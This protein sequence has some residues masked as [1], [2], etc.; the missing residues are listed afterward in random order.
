MRRHWKLLLGIV[1][2]LVLALGAAGYV[3]A[4]DLPDPMPET[5]A[6]LV[7]DDVVAVETEPWLAFIPAEPAE[8]GFIFYPGGRVPAQAY[9]PPAR[10]IAQAGYLTVVPS[11]PFGLAVLAPDTADGIIEAYPEV[12]RWVIG[13]HS[14]G[15]A[16]AA[17]YAASHDTIEGLALWAAYPAGGTDLS[18]AP[19]AATSIYAS[20]DGLA[21]IEEI[22]GS[23]VQLPPDT[24]FVEIVGGNHAGFGWYGPQ[25]G[26]G[27]ATIT[28]EEQQ[29]QVVEATLELLGLVDA[30]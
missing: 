19:L 14:L 20:E 7:S 26:D 22:E 3:W 29:A 21:T 17:D 18:E 2:V 12:T 15:G 13:G 9:A 27:E 28:R 4:T 24:T 5:E 8:T 11:M 23:R 6:A 25:D 30:S 16:M 10:A 1:A